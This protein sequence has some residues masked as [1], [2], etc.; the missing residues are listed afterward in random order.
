MIV[1]LIAATTILSPFVPWA[2][3]TIGFGIAT[4]LYQAVAVSAVIA[5]VIAFVA[6]RIALRNAERLLT[7]AEM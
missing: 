3:S 6:Y 5:V 2:L 1:C 4:D 7:K